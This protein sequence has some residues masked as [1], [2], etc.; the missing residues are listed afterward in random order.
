MFLCFYD[1]FVWKSL[2]FEQKRCFIWTEVLL[3]CNNISVLRFIKLSIYQIN[4]LIRFCMRYVDCFFS[5]WGQILSGCSITKILLFLV[6]ENFV[7]LLMLNVYLRSHNPLKDNNTLRDFKFDQ[8]GFQTFI[9]DSL[10][11]LEVAC[12]NIMHKKSLY[13]SNK[14]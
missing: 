7:E 11:F 3:P 10:D 14:M 6:L 9:S 12:E 8:I 1:I 13:I 4:R 2:F 5:W